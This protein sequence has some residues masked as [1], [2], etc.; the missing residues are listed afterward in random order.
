MCYVSLCIQ[1][2]DSTEVIKN[3]DI[4]NGLTDWNGQNGSTLSLAYYT[5]ASGN[6]GLK[7]SGRTVPQ[8]DHPRIL[9]A[10]Y[11]PEKLIMSRQRFS[12]DRMKVIQT[13]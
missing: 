6:L 2:S 13:A 4:E 1:F 7:A 9:L 3:G 12:I 5:K 11:R 8:Q 10:G